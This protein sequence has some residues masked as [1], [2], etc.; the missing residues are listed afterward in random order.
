M[1]LSGWTSTVSGSRRM[2]YLEKGMRMSHVEFATSTGSNG[3]DYSSGFDIAGNAGKF[4][5]ERIMF[6]AAATVRSAA[7]GAAGSPT[8][9]GATRLVT[10]IWDPRTGKLRFVSGAS[11]E[12]GAGAEIAA[13]DVISMLVVGV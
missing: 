11:V 13:T 7:G 1:P 3:A 2:D 5:F 8:S 6:V 9:A 12:V 4:G 10:P